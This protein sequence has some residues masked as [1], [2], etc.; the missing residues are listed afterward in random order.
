MRNGMGI[1]TI[2]SINVTPPSINYKTMHLSASVLQLLNLARFGMYHYPK[3]TVKEAFI[4]ALPISGIDGT[5]EHRLTAPGLI[6][7]VKAKTGTMANVTSLSGFIYTK[8]NIIRH[9]IY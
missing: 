5:L 2:P 1:T 4:T 8:S 3:S 9:N 7:K 6:G